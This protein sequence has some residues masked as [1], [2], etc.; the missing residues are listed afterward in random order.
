MLNVSPYD[1]DEEP[2]CNYLETVTLKDLPIFVTHNAPVSDDFTV[3][4]TND[5]N[6][7]GSYIVTIKSEISVPDDYTMT[8]FTILSSEHAF[9]VFIQ[10]CLVSTYEATTI[11]NAII[12]NVNQAL[13]IDGFY[14]FD[15]APVCNYPQ[16]V[17]VTNLPSFANHNEPSSDFTIPQNNNLS[18][19]GEYI[20][21]LRSEIQVPDDYTLTSYTSMFVKYDFVIQ[22]EECLVT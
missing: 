5:L 6:L 22:V 4:Q 20:V 10:P 7:I 21:T 9:T 3:L 19:I 17:T 11:V 12:Y 2:V 13:L 1:F 15:I 18:L 16:I 14:A 8:S